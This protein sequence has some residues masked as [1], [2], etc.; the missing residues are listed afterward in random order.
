[1]KILCASDSFLC[2]FMNCR[3]VSV[4]KKLFP[5]CFFALYS[6][7]SKIS[8]EK[9]EE[10]VYYQVFLYET[11]YFLCKNQSTLR[12]EQ[13]RSLRS[14]AKRTK[15]KT[16]QKARQVEPLC[17]TAATWRKKRHVGAP[18]DLSPSCAT[19]WRREFTMVSSADGFPA[20]LVWWRRFGATQGPKSLEMPLSP[21]D[22]QG[23]SR[24]IPSDP[25]ESL[26]I[27]VVQKTP[28][29]THETGRLLYCCCCR[30]FNQ[31]EKFM[32]RRD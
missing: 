9:E 3:I 7:K 29:H 10:T 13:K 6:R 16:A 15:Q 26:P 1:M 24:P 20:G 18:R 8:I 28:Q 12:S 22:T 27:H 19:K 25:H 21:F 4:V 32:R 30:R 17:E 23:L 2:T 5:I 31:I 14:L 11:V